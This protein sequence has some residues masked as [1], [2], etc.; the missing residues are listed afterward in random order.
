MTAVGLILDDEFVGG[1]S[2]ASRAVARIEQSLQRCSWN[3]YAPAEAHVRQLMMSHQPVGQAS[4]NTQE[5][6]CL[7]DRD[8]ESGAALGGERFGY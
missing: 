2:A 7:L 3:D 6:A 5:P 4:R 8:N 1:G